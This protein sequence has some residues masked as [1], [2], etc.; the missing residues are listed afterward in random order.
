M[1]EEPQV[2]KH[3]ELVCYTL[4]A[5]FILLICGVFIG[6]NFGDRNYFISPS[7]NLISSENTEAKGLIDLNTASSSELQM[8]PGI[9]SVLAQR[10]IDY[11]LENGGFDSVNEL[12]NVQGI[13]QQT[14][15]NLQNYVTVE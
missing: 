10:I 14:F 1:Q 7:E 15:E 8:I 12:M 3:F 9:G 4:L 6:R 2:K 13:G 11:R 5:A